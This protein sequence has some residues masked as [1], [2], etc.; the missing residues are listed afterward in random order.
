VILGS[1]NKD[2]SRRTVYPTPIGAAPSSIHKPQRCVAS[3]IRDA[4][5]VP[6]WDLVRLALSLWL[7]GGNEVEPRRFITRARGN[8][9]DPLALS[10]SSRSTPVCRNR[11][12]NAEIRETKERI[13]VLLPNRRQ[14]CRRATQRVEELI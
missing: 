14:P 12:G 10:R 8:N 5:P 13:A 3:I 4:T 6:S 7:L 1:E 11:V 9:V 2:T